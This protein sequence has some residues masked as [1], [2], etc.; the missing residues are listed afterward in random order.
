MKKAFTLIELLVVIAIIA[1]LAAILFPVFA[2]AKESARQSTCLSNTRQIGMA[3]ALYAD[4]DSDRYPAWAALAPPINGGNSSYIPPDVQ[5]GPYMR[6]DQIWKCP[7]DTGVRVDPNTVPWWDGTYRLRKLPRSYSYVGQINTVEA[8]GIDRNTGMFK[9]VGPGTWDMAGRTS[10]EFDSTSETISWVEQWSVGV[11]DQY[12]GGIWGSG[13]INCDT[14]KLAGRNIPAR[15]PADLGPPGCASWY[16][17]KPTPGHRKHGVY[18]FADGHSK[19]LPWGRVRLND[20]YYFK[21]NKP[22]TQFSP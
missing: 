5:V 3:T 19:V 9:W 12:V 15:G 13:F 10:N 18:A 21:V 20:F 8:N 17:N 14:C 16:A 22:V 1:I 6:S 7:S 2:Q 11:A 4:N